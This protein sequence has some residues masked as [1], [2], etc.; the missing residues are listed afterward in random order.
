VYRNPDLYYKECNS[1]VLI[2]YLRSWEIGTHTEGKRE[3]G[4]LSRRSYAVT[5]EAQTW[6]P[7][8]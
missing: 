1:K 4:G 2:I 8:V 6:L 5:C 3:E 7:L